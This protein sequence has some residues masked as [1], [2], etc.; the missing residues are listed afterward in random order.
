MVS[1]LS[2][3]YRNRSDR[4]VVDELLASR[5]AVV[6]SAREKFNT[7]DPAVSR[8]TTGLLTS[9]CRP[10]RDRH[11]PRRPAVRSWSG[12]STSY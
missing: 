10:T 5:R 8:A 11:L 9:S 4:A 1:E 12:I 7:A 2:R 3:L 6:G